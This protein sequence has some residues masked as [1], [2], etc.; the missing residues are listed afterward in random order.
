[1]ERHGSY[2]DALSGELGL[3]ESLIDL[4]HQKRRAILDS[5][6]DRI[7][8]ITSLEETRLDDVLNLRNRR[9]DMLLEILGEGPGNRPSVAPGGQRRYRL[10]ATAPDYLR[11][12]LSATID[13]YD[14]NLMALRRETQINNTLLADRLRV[15]G[16]TLEWIQTSV[17]EKESYER[18]KK[19]GGLPVLVNQVV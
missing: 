15:M 5:D 1:M 12:K 13:R 7:D 16:R 8:G 11:P 19:T 14:A 3:I 6:T 4:A 18:R 10:L 9:R 2:L 17:I